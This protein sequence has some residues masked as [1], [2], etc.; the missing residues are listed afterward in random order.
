MGEY[1]EKS[2]RNKCPR[3]VQSVPSLSLQK[4][5]CN[6]VDFICSLGNYFLFY[7]FSFP[8]LPKLG[9]DGI[10]STLALYQRPQCFKRVGS[11][12]T[13][14]AGGH[15]TLT[16]HPRCFRGLTWPHTRL[17]SCDLWATGTWGLSPSP[18]EVP[19][20]PYLFSP[21]VSAQSGPVVKNSS[22]PP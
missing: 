22:A 9:C 13:E 14:L 16:T 4:Q 3:V 11:S 7:L 5:T 18:E 20:Q 8:L 10:L 21:D 17:L 19:S 15:P 6:P 2:Q 12:P 1:S